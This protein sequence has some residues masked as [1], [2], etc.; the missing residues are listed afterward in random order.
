MPHAPILLLHLWY[1][2]G[3][4]SQLSSNGEYIAK[5][6]GG[7]SGVWVQPE[8]LRSYKTFVLGA[9]ID[10]KTGTMETNGIVFP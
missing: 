9:Q 2:Q 6:E 8:C 7:A 1:S 3:W 10:Q 4:R 5:S